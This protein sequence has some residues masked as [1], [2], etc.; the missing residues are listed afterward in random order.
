MT[1][2][3]P[4]AWL[5]LADAA[6][7]L[8]QQ[9]IAGLF[10]VDPLR[11][12]YFSLDAAA[13]HL[14]FSKNLLE[15]ATLDLLLDLAVECEL[16]RKMTAMFDGEHINRSEDRAVLHT[17]LR[18]PRDESI[19]VDG[20]PT[21]PA[22]TQV[23]NQMRSCIDALHAGSWR[24]FDGKRIT[25]VVNIGIGGSHLGPQL[26]CDALRYFAL[27]KTTV[28]FVSN[29]DGGEIDKVLSRLDP[30]TT[31]FIVA[32]K[33]FT[34]PETAL[35]AGTAKAWLLQSAGDERAIAKH[36][37]A[38][39]AHP[40]RTT[41]FGIAPENVFPMWDWVGGRYSLWSAIGLPIALQIGMDNFERMLSG[42]AAMDQHFRAAPLAANM[43]V[44]LALIGIWNTNFLGAESLA[45]VPYDDR[46]FYLSS[47]LQQLEMESNGKRI[48]LD[49]QPVGNDT[50]PILWGGLGTNVQHAFFQL[51]HQGT[52]LIPV[53]F[54]MTLRHPRA[55]LAHQ[56]MLIANCI[57]QAEALMCG[58]SRQEL[59]GR[60]TAP[61]DV[62]LPL[63]REQPGNQPSNMIVLDELTPET[64]G[65]LLALYEHKTFV[66]GVIWNINSFDQWGVELGKQ[67]ASRLLDEMAAGAAG[68]HD[69]STTAL[70]SRYLARRGS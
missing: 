4:K 54:I 46:L 25:D 21:A 12:R 40:A 13:L 63:Q 49:N 58:R 14:D 26:A 27:D 23:L 57:A 35:N 2:T 37:L 19:L 69:G 6:K 10:S 39:S 64:L 66:Q 68:S 32:S 45:V 36:F 28:H 62:D 8:K 42:A 52:R 17:A 31:V 3:S 41:A 60:G 9:R 48:T 1:T 16:P 59:A 47:Y 15:Q 30:A 33:S 44:L 70:V 67:L 55:P 20:T 5:R 29:V 50:A 38:I 61:A 51:L 43:P 11:S 22:V 65:A 56:D 24:G 53:D 18:N 7:Q 34:T